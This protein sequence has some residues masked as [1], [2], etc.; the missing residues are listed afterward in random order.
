MSSRKA[1]EFLERNRITV[2]R[3]QDADHEKLNAHDALALARSAARVVVA[4]GKKVITYDMTKDAPD[5]AALQRH[6]LNVS[7]HLRTPTVLKRQTLL[8]GFNND[9]YRRYLAR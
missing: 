8:V 4:K 7:G 1:Q 6:L 5:E 2:N 9:V 3:F